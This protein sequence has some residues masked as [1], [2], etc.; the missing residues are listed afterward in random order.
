MKSGTN[1]WHG[2]AYYF[3]RNPALNARPNSLT[4]QKS[5]VRRNVWGATSGNPIVANKVFNFFA[6]EGQQTSEPRTREIT[7]PTSLERGG[8]FSNS[9][10]RTGGLRRIF[11]PFTTQITGPTSS[12]REPFANNVI[13]S[14]RLDP[15]AQFVMSE[16]WQPNGPGDNAAGL[17]NFRTVYPLAFKYYNFSDRVDWNVSDNVKV[18]GRISRF[19]TDQT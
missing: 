6:Y 17:N 2:T 19:H 1:D 7:L 4:N 18:F 14:S 12:T 9:F 15:T 5:I 10:N 8:D 16:L 3:G 13:P 11:D